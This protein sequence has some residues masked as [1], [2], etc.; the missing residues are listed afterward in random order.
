MSAEAHRPLDDDTGTPAEESALARLLESYLADLEAGRPAD[1][2]RL[3]AA[4]PALAGPF[5]PV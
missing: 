1:P 4:Y 2:E 5:A 3:I